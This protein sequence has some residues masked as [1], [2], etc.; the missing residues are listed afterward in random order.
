MATLHYAETVHIAQ[1][2]IPTPYFCIA[3]EAK[4]ESESGP[5]SVSGNVNEPYGNHQKSTS[6]TSSDLLT[7]TSLELKLNPE[8]LQHDFITVTSQ[9]NIT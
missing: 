4:T 6:E 7:A 1:T 3:Q 8:T 2:W 9:Q 5:E